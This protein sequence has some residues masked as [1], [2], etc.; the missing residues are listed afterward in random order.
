MWGGGSL[1]H[2]ALQSSPAAA[3]KFFMP[4]IRAKGVKL[5]EFVPRSSRMGTQ[6]ECTATDTPFLSE[7]YLCHGLSNSILKQYWATRKMCKELLL[8]GKCDYVSD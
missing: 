8:A 7:A 5:P 2:F 3:G 4:P 6:E 1:F